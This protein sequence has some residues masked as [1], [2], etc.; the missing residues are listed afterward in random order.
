MCCCSS[1]Q[2]GWTCQA[3]RGIWMWP[4]PLGGGKGTS[5]SGLNALRICGKSLPPFGAIEL[6]ASLIPSPLG[7]RL[8]PTV[9]TVLRTHGPCSSLLSH[10]CD[11]LLLWSGWM[12][13]TIPRAHLS[14]K[15]QLRGHSS[16]TFWPQA[17]PMETKTTFLFTRSTCVHVFSSQTHHACSSCMLSP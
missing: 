16:R 1:T 12:S 8:Q 2:V 4:R 10:L 14:F 9:L 17:S 5:G 3:Q 11:L 13:S 6:P 15:A 7:C